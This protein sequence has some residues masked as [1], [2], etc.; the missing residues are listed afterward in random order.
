MEETQNYVIFG[1]TGGIG[2]SLARLLKQRWP[3]RLY[4]CGRN[5]GVL[6]ELAEELD[7]DIGQL[8]GPIASEIERHIGIAQTKY[9]RIDGL[10]NCIG[11]L[12]LKPAHRTSNADW[13]DVLETNLTSAFAIVR[14][15]GQHMRKHGGSVLLISS[16]AARLGL[17]NH[18]AIGAAKA[19]VEGLTRSAAA[20]YARYGIRFNAVAPGLTETPMT[21]KLLRQDSQ[22]RN[23]EAMVPLGRIGR[24]DDISRTACWLLNPKND[25]LTAQVIAVDGGLSSSRKAVSRTL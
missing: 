16:V 14:G 10:V 13:L 22:R 4:L 11:N 25:W 17:A 15:A 19:G 18:D 24:P 3:C 5:R 23:A 20:S 1:A 12:Y 8:D 6:T 21:E 2:Q 7:A 9:G